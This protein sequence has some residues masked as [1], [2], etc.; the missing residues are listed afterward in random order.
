MPP[1]PRPDIRPGTLETITEVSEEDAI[2]TLRSSRDQLLARDND[3]Q[4]F[5]DTEIAVRSREATDRLIAELNGEIIAGGKI[6]ELS[7]SRMRAI[8]EVDPLERIRELHRG[9]DEVLGIN[10]RGGD[11]VV[12]QLVADDAAASARIDLGSAAVDGCLRFLMIFL[13]SAAVGLVALL[14]FAIVKAC[15]PRAA[16]GTSADQPLDDSPLGHRIV[17]LTSMV[18]EAAADRPG[19]FQ[20][21]GVSDECYAQVRQAVVDGQGN[22]PESL[23]WQL[24]ADQALQPYPQ[25]DILFTPA[26]HYMALAFCLDI[27]QPLYPPQPFDL[28]V[29]QTIEALASTL[30]LDDRTCMAGYYNRM[31]EMIPEDTGVNRAQRIFLA[32][33]GLARAFSRWS[34]PRG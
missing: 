17:N 29:D 12:N 19:S 10:P 22:V 14:I 11:P 13:G 2:E 23:W 7:A 24:L 15:E 26:N 21:L 27:L 9:M 6:L 25:T 33:A 3:D 31:L 30:K 20:E 8:H 32:R 28:D 4:S 1:R 5:R 34:D 18:M 16:F